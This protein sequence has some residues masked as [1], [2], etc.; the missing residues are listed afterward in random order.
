MIRKAVVTLVCAF[1]LLSSGAALADRPD[2]DWKSWFG[3]FAVGY[4]TIDGDEG[5]EA[6]EDDWYV[7]G[8]ATLWPD[9]SP[10]GLNLNASYSDYDAKS[11]VIRMIND[12]LEADG[13]GRPLTGGD[14]SLWGI[15][16]DGVWGTRG[17]GTFGFSVAAGA[18]L[19]YYDTRVLAP[20][21]VTYPPVCGWYWCVPGGVAPGTVAA[22]VDSDWEWGW[23]VGVG[24][25]FEVGN[26]GSQ[27]YVEVKYHEIQTDRDVEI[28]P[29]VIGYRW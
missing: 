4:A 28:T 20:G 14:A 9:S 6:F 26:S 5:G 18:G 22:K 17:S 13:Q 11:S 29:L 1:A 7:E 2:K 3:N 24:V 10:V 25:S 15:T 8:G 19:Y 27:I 12:A 23:N 21:I 16:A